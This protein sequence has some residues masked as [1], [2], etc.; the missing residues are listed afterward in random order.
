[1]TNGSDH[2]PNGKEKPE[3]RAGVRIMLGVRA[4]DEELRC[5]EFEMPA[6]LTFRVLQ[7]AAEAGSRG[8][9]R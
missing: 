4:E 2:V 1:M 6:E 7:R 5:V 9:E 3:G 8:Q